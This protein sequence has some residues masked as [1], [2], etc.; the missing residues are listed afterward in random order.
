MHHIEIFLICS[1]VPFGSEAII[2]P[3]LIGGCSTSLAA[4]LEGREEPC[5]LI[6]ICQPVWDHRAGCW[7]LNVKSLGRPSTG[8]G[9]L[10]VEMLE[11]YASNASVGGDT[12]QYSRR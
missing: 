9:E 8:G 11:V 1:L 7:P 10:K 3:G 4:H 12:A 2:I 6:G 5:I